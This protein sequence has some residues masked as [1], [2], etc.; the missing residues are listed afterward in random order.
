MGR[1]GKKKGPPDKG[2]WGS[3]PTGEGGFGRKNASP[4]PLAIPRLK[5]QPPQPPLDR[6]VKATPLD[7]GG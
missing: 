7:R 4:A 3:N 6:G 2:G 1:V 5:K